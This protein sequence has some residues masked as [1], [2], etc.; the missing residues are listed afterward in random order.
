MPIQCDMKSCWCVDVHYGNEIAG[1]RISKAMRRAD[2]CRGENGNLHYSSRRCQNFDIAEFR[3]CF[4]RC[5]NN[6]AHGLVMDEYGCPAAQCKC[7]EICD[8][9]K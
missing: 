1:S 2:M 7:R 8:K 9:V 4:H 3:L 6:C 5:T